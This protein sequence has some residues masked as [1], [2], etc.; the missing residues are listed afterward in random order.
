MSI[1]PSTLRV[2]SVVRLAPLDDLPRHLFKV[3]SIHDGFVTGVALTGPLR[4][5]YGE[6]ETDLIEEVVTP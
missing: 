2:G 1:V 3:H 4:D 6:P 5:T